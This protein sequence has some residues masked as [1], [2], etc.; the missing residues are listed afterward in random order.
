MAKTKS[1]FD[2]VSDEELRHEL[3]GREADRRAAIN[4]ANQENAKLVIEHVCLRSEV[5]DYMNEE[6]TAA[7]IGVRYV[8]VW[9]EYDVQRYRPFNPDGLPRLIEGAQKRVARLQQIQA[10]IEANG[11]NV[12]MAFADGL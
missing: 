7:T 4:K 6:D 12:P 11:N 5:V 10:D 3:I 1:K 2:D 9:M 8:Q